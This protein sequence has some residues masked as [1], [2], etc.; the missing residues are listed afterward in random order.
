MASCNILH[1]CF[2]VNTA[3]KWICYFLKYSNE[4]VG[5]F[6][7]EAMCTKVLRLPCVSATHG[8]AP[9]LCAVHCGAI[10]YEYCV[11][12][13]NVWYTTMH[14]LCIIEQCIANKGFCALWPIVVHWQPIHNDLISLTWH[15]WTHHNRSS[16]YESAPL[17]WYL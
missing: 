17:L 2:L 6:T 4:I 8:N 7:A 11:V 1:L 12:E 9:A 3:L 13:C 14:R 10:Y 5:T 16:K 15:S